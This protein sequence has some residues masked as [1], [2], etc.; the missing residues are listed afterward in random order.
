MIKKRRKARE[1][2]PGAV[3]YAC[4]IY[5]FLYLPIFVV[6]AFSFNSS[7]M[8]IV[9]EHFTVEWYFKMFDNRQLMQSFVN[10]IIVAGIS[11]VL[12]VIIGTLC[13]LGLYKF[14]FRLKNVLSSSL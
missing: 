12:S 2:G 1:F 9:F 14:E 5:L 8:N 11:T 6:I 4:L 3:A 7:K 13:A 10:T